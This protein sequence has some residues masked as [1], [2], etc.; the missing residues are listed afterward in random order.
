VQSS[1]TLFIIGNHNRAS[2][3]FTAATLLNGPRGGVF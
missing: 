2:W 1:V 3:H